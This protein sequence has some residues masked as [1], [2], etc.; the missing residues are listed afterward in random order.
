MAEWL[1]LELL[2]ALDACGC[3]SIST[4][5]TGIGVLAWDDI[6]GTLVVT[7]VRRYAS[8]R[9][10]DEFQELVKCD[11]GDPVVELEVYLVRCVPTPNDQGVPP[12]ET[13]LSEAHSDILAD[14]ECI[15]DFLRCGELPHSEA[16]KA[17]LTQRFVGSEGGAVM[18]TTTITYGFPAA[19]WGTA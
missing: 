12:S 3:D 19:V 13:A 18:V 14:A 6:C 15:M 8:T 7:P 5:Y 11:A 1:R 17:N 9:F 2:D 16:E 4:S 10:P